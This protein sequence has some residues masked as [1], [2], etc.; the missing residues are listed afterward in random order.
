MFDC[1]T[2]EELKA[3]MEEQ[4]LGHRK[5]IQ[6]MFRVWMQQGES[7]SGFVCGTGGH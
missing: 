5:A 7:D 2:E 4:S 1:S 3:K 6:D